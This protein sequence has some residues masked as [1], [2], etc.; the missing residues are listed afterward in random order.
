M[1]ISS[2]ILP[3]G[4]GRSYDCGPMQAV[5]K[6]DGAETQGR[7]SVSEWTVAPHSH[8][9]GPHSHEENEELFLVT[10]GTMAVRVG[11]EWIDAPRGTFLRIPAGVIH[12]FENRTDKPAT[13]FN[14]FL[15]GAF[16]HMMPDIVR[17]FAGQK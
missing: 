17:W 5:F 6:A 7:Y 14:V 8:G 12:D 9:P 11:E 10:E 3:P 15:P 2:I 13:L 4:C 16:E 1:S